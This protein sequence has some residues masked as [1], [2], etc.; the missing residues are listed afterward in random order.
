MDEENDDDLHIKVKN[1][2]KLLCIKLYK[3]KKGSGGRLC[4]VEA[5]V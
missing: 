1:N 5:E 4:I 3:R 2:N